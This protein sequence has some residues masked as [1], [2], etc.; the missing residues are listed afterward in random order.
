MADNMKKPA[1]IRAAMSS[2][3]L[4]LLPGHT[5]LAAD[6][7]APEV[8]DAYQSS[9][10]RAWQKAVEG[11]DPSGTCAG[12]KGRTM[13]A[14]DAEAFQALFACN[15][16]IPVRYFE[17]YLDEVEAGAKDCQG[18]MV[19]V[20]TKLPAMTM[21]TDALNAMAESVAESGDAE[22][23]VSEALGPA[24]AEAMTETGLEDPKRLIKDRIDPRT[25][26]LCPQFADVILN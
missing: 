13:N 3:A 16:D 12:V 8:G 24:A 19:E 20:M 11:R 5:I 18:F 4:L 7:E 6:A 10:D 2:L 26:E 21:S 1:A 9:I 15:V 14:Q 17:T 22:T 23:A 25:R